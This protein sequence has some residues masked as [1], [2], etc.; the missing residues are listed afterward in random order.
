MPANWIEWVNAAQTEAESKRYGTASIAA[1]PTARKTGR[2]K[3]RLR[4]D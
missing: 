2:S 3:F 1:H 4:S